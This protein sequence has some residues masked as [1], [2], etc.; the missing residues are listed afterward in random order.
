MHE[1]ADEME[2]EKRRRAA[3]TRSLLLKDMD[4]GLKPPSR[5]LLEAA[6]R[7]RRAGTQA[8]QGPAPSAS[9]ATSPGR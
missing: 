9:A 4:L 2:F 5:A 8:A 6:V 3:A 7:R 1:A